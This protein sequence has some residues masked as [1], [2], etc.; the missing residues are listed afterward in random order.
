MH[1]KCTS[2]HGIALTNVKKELVATNT[3]F[4]TKRFEDANNQI[5]RLKSKNI[6]KHRFSEIY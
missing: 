3:L 1:K 5:Q 6:N 4:L 2:P